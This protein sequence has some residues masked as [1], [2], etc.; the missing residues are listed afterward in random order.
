MKNHKGLSGQDTPPSAEAIKAIPMD[1]PEPPPAS[2]WD[3]L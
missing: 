2:D 3:K 1:D